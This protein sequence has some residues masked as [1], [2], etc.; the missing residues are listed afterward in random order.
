MHSVNKKRNITFP[1]RII[2]TVKALH[3]PTDALYI[4]LKKPL[5]CTL[6]FKLKLPLQVSVYDHHQGAYT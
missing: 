1:L 5:K 2:R 3:L 6:K 4:I